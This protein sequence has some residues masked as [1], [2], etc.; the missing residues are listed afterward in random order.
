MKKLFA[1][2]LAV[3]MLLSLGV[4]AFADG[5]I[6]IA[7]PPANVSYNAYKIF[8]ATTSGT[9]V[10]YS[11]ADTDPWYS[12]LFTTDEDGNVI[13]KADP[14]KFTVESGTVT[15]DEGY[16]AAK[17]AEWIMTNVDLSGLT[18]VPSSAPD[19][20]GNV[21]IE[22]LEE[23]YY[24]IVP[25]TSVSDGKFT[26]A[27]EEEI[28]PYAQWNTLDDDVKDVYTAHACWYQADDGDK[29]IIVT[30][31]LYD[32]TNGVGT[33]GAAY[34]AG[35]YYTRKDDIDKTAFEKLPAD[36]QA[37]YSS[38]AATYQFTGAQTEINQDDYDDLDPAQKPLYD[39]FK[40][41]Y[42][43][44]Q[45]DGAYV[46]PEVY[47]AMGD[48]QRALYNSS[49]DTRYKPKTIIPAKAYMNLGQ[50]TDNDVRLLQSQY[51]P[52]TDPNGDPV[53]D[54]TKTPALTTVL[55]GQT[56]YVQNKN[57]MPLDKQVDTDGDDE[58]DDDETSVK[59]GDTLNYKIKTKIPT[60]YADNNYEY[61]FL[62][63][64]KMSKGLDFNDDIQI[65]IG[66]EE[67]PDIT[68][69]LSNGAA[70]VTKNG[71]TASTADEIRAAIGSAFE[72]VAATNDKT[73]SGNEIRYGANGYT[74]ELSFNVAAQVLRQYAG[75]DLTIKYTADVTEDALG[76]LIQNVATLDYTD[77]NGLH[78][79]DSETDNYMARIVV[80]KFETGNREQKLA[81]AKFVLYKLYDAEDPDFYGMDAEDAYGEPTR[82]YYTYNDTDESTGWTATP[83]SAYEAETDGNG[84]AEFRYVPDGTYYLHETVAPTNYKLLL[85][86]IKVVVDG[87]D[88][89]DNR[90]TQAQ[91]DAILNPVAHVANT[92]GSTM[93]STG[94][95][96]ATLLTIGGVALML[97][98]GAFLILRRKEQE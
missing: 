39:S 26:Y 40:V 35:S 3:V 28:L 15:A 89:V 86:D 82:L 21:L 81:G 11:I 38:N 54:T 70:T 80:D 19:A 63:T 74:F 61:E 48:T 85:E 33:D 66:D 25:M 93:P 31:E 52:V 45:D 50:S 56:V 34:V 32:L 6:K 24:L 94:G 95:V 44:G 10:V 22:N 55:N 78:S 98:A 1:V 12:I 59:V 5:Q 16:S 27:G 20:D 88:A 13:G 29:A 37:N 87:S 43:S 97:A 83:G 53:V 75:E 7:D 47:N 96:G 79:K 23:G 46:T 76:T 42:L 68:I 71:V 17:F 90:L 62:I 51:A 92:P 8:G 4:T 77:E 84:F 41:H 64:D 2:L 30:Q 57:D 65:L 60:T 69:V 9:D 36:E 72:F 14:I 67:N 73:L 18:A 91:R 58:Y 49:A